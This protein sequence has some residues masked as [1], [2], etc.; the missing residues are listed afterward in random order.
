[1]IRESGTLSHHAPS[2]ISG[3][4][5]LRA[6]FRTPPDTHRPVP[7]YWWAGGKLDRKRIG[8]QLD[9]LC[10]KGVRQTVISYPHGPD[11]ECDRGDP[12]LFTPEW[13]DFFRWFLDACKER[14]MTAGIQDYTISEPMLV[15]IGRSTADMQGG[16]LGCEWVHMKGGESTRWE[17][18]EGCKALV[19]AAYPWREGRAWAEGRVEVAVDALS[20]SVEWQAPEGEWVLT[21]C[22]I[23]ES[24]FDPLHP[25]SGALAIGKLYEPYERECPEHLGVTLNLFFQD[26]LNFGGRMP[27][28]SNRLFEVFTAQK[29]YDLRPLLP[30]LWLDLGPQ[31][32]KIRMDYGDV[33]SRRIE[34]RY[35]RPVFEWMDSRGILFG[36]DNGGRGRIRE[37]R[38]YYGDYFRTMRWFSAP[39]CDDPRIQGPRAFKGLKVNSSIAHL[40]GRPRVWMEGFHSSGWG[41]RPAELVD[42]VCEDLVYGASVINL[43]GLYHDTR[44]GWWEWAAPDFHFRQP[45]WSHCGPLN[46]GFTRLC[47]M[48]TRGAHRCEVGMVYPIEAIDAL[49][50]EKGRAPVIAHIGNA[51]IDDGF[52]EDPEE[53][54]FR[55]GRLIFDQGM[56]FDF[57]DRDS[58]ARAV[59]SDGQLHAADARYRVMILPSMA[60]L[61][62]ATALRLKEFVAAGG[63][64]I[65]C[66]VMP[67]ASDHQG[68][69]DSQIQEW[70][71]D[72]FG[73]T[74][75][76]ADVL[77][78]HPEGGEALWIRKS[79][80]ALLGVL[81]KVHRTPFTASH[82]FQ[83]LHRRDQQVDIH[84]VRN[85]GSDSLRLQWDE[86]LSG[87]REVWDPWTGDMEVI[88]GGSVEVPPR[89]ARLM[90]SY[91]GDR[92][93][94]TLA[95]PRSLEAGEI[96]LD[97]PWTS[98]I[99]P[100]LDNQHGDFRLPATG[101][102]MGP[103]A[104]RFRWR[105]EHQGDVVRTW[106][107][108]DHEDSAWEETSYSFG[109]QMEWSGPFSGN[110][111]A[112]S[113]ESPW[114]W[115]LYHFSRQWGIERDP[116]L[117]DW[118]SGPHG[119]KGEVPDA[120]L[121][122]DGAKPGDWWWVRGCWYVDSPGTHRLVS[123]GRC[124]H[125]VWV[126]GQ[127]VLDLSDALE[128][129]KHAPWSIPHYDA[130]LREATVLLGAGANEVRIRVVQPEGQRARC[131]VALDPQEK[132]SDTPELRWYAAG[133]SSLP[134]LRAAP[135]RRAVWFRFS[136]PPG[137][138]GLCFSAKGK[139]Q[140][141]LNG[142]PLD[143]RKI[144]QGSQGSIRYRADADSTELFP[145]VAVLRVEAAPDSLGG[146]VLPDPVAFVTGEGLIFPGDWCQ[147][148]L[149]C[150]SGLIEYRQ[151]I[152][153]SASAGCRQ[154][155]LDLGDVRASAEVKINGQSIATLLAPPWRCEIGPWLQEGQNR[156]S[157]LVANTLSNHYSVG[158]P[159]PYLFPEQNCSGLLGPVKILLDS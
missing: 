73:S 137:T 16:Q 112:G 59:M 47:W 68:A 146:D 67:R 103:E 42:A 100:V 77:R 51:D 22:F 7:F 18:E 122:F 44:G 128:P 9:Q 155:S 31:T 159:T 48:L 149:S 75:G 116:F 79:P 94:R 95:R 102:L 82:P 6:G 56:D 38:S 139:A 53:C 85:P 57:V 66:G 24:P 54:A 106:F 126:N 45:Y 119:L 81:R 65:V 1:M 108:P 3:L 30:A 23:W 87:I 150:Y 32:E 156:I 132:T 64:L 113:D 76:D 8:W 40:Y 101:G 35:F 21:C 93:S 141:W 70:V 89:S 131:F 120:Y 80:Q 125:E 78:Q 88:H 123:A 74:K 36:Q 111:H 143:V 5:A 135:S 142:K 11:G 83:L 138:Q 145:S 96:V 110:L 39:G 58:I 52:H 71:R 91:P 43:H 69:E 13:W 41:V 37:G 62:C 157:I 60:A 129:G 20:G 121:D 28:W 55:L 19:A 92:P 72:L 12:A 17:L 86:R 104:R 152:Q 140:A 25:D 127:K 84:F 50:A 99:H 109:P 115:R 107:H 98:V 2:A 97:G 14:G 49:P 154:I 33:V 148:G 124:A 136:S 130:E 117:V 4:A 26:E 153:W 46:D 144:G 158:V 105:D 147:Q 10:E 63:K 114:D 134:S 34:E 61:S 27:F 90:V 15:E 118:L 151:D 29:A 133:S